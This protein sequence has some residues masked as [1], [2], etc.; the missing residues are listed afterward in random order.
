MK[1]PGHAMVLSLKKMLAMA[2]P[3][4]LIFGNALGFNPGIRNALRYLGLRLR[5]NL[6][7]RDR[8]RWYRYRLRQL[9]GRRG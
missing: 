4:R 2:L 7:D 3:F 5:R 1:T 8:L 9:L 6:T